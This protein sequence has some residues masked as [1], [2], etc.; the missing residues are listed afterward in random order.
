MAKPYV[1]P[2]RVVLFSLA[3]GAGLVLVSL[4]P[5]GKWSITESWSLKWPQLH[6]LLQAD[7]TPVIDMAAMRQQEIADSLALVEALAS[8][9]SLTIMTQNARKHQAAIH[10]PEGHDTLFHPLFRAL[11]KSKTSELVRIM[12]YGDSQIEIDRLTEVVREGLQQKFGGGGPGLQPPLQ[13]IPSGTVKQTNLGNFRRFAIWSPDS[14]SPGHRRYGPLLNFTHVQGPEAQ[15]QFSPGFSISP[16]ARNYGRIKILAG[17]ATEEV[18]VSVNG[19]SQT[20]SPAQSF[21]SLSFDVAQPGGTLSISF[22]TTESGS[23]ELYGF[24]LESKQGVVV[25]NLP[26]RGCSGT[27][28]TRVDQSLLFK[29]WDAL[30]TDA[31]WLEFGGNAVPS[32]ESQAE[33]GRFARSFEQQ[34]KMFKKYNPNLPIL[35]IGPSD[36]ST[37]IEGEFQPYP[38]LDATRDS[39]KAAVFRQGC[40]Y[41]DMIEA[42]GGLGAM[43]AWVKESPP[44]AGGDYIHFTPAGAK[45]MGDILL[46]SFL[47][48]FNLYTL[49]KK[50][51]HAS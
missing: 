3:I 12:H 23:F 8:Q 41:F 14:V 49:R 48:E 32:I 43:P 47:R 13:V 21:Q 24:S 31:L 6:K 38:F 10:Y 35:V 7:T 33:A 44:L 19:Q 45:K 1:S 15:V 29:G 27:I 37:R 26:M 4:I 46:Q 28:F 2:W 9:D 34:L 25:D 22:S 39:L 36:M 40:A 17:Q 16:K 18:T 50:K 5:T 30:G 11:E 20:L 51:H 42:M